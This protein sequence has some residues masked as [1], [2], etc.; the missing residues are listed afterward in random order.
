ML[1][2]YH[3]PRC[4]KSRE[5]LE[6]LKTKSED[7]EVVEYLKEGLTE[8]IIKEIV[9]KTNL[10]PI[11]LIRT[12]EDVFKKEFKGKNFTDEEWI[13]IIIENPKLLQRPLIV[14]KQKAVIARPAEKVDEI[15]K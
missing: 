7:F 9:L 8:D 15:V 10:K 14:G 6:Y 1:K 4:S 2:I 5:G 13:E 12:Q 3:N 11:E